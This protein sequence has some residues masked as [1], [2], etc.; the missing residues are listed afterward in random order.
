MINNIV[1]YL[2][3]FL[4][5]KRIKII[6]DYFLHVIL[7]AKGY[8]NSGSFKVTGEDLF[9]KKLSKFK[10]N[11]CLD[12][13]A[14]SGNYSQML[15]QKLNANVIAIEPMKDPFKDLLKIKKKY[16]L[17]FFPYNYAF[18]NKI[19][20][21]Y[22]YF[23][24]KNSQLST[25]CE[26]YNYIN[27]LKKKKFRSKRIKVITL[28][29]FVEKNLYH[30]KKGLDL[31]KIDTEGNDYNVL[32]G[33]IN[34]IERYKPKF[35]QFEMNYHY[36]FNFV[37]IYKFSRLFKN[38]KI[39]RILP[40]NNGFVEVNPYRPENNIFHLSNYIFVKKNIKFL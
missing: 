33:G 29:Y 40:Y 8:K 3:K 13:G 32:L 37:N 26:N 16:P 24:N 25:L 1:N 2:V 5:L 4:S 17:R 12:I 18:S 22:I 39:Y 30:F 27:F 31:I 28:D 36:I 14:H 7:R 9:F 35:I 20:Y 10:L 11:T 6:N 19:G 15:I 34:T 23:P 38:Y 21:Q